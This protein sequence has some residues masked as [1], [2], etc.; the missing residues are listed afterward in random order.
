MAKTT[1][2]P[3]V[4]KASELGKSHRCG[5]YREKNLFLNSESNL[6]FEKAIIIKDSIKALLKEKAKT[7][8][9]SEDVRKEVFEHLME[10][11]SHM[12]YKTQ[13]TARINAEDAYRQIMRY[14]LCETRTPL[15]TLPAVVDVCGMQVKVAPTMVFLTS[16]GVEVV[17]LSASKPKVT[18]KGRKLDDSANSNLELYAMIQYGKRYI[19]QGHEATVKASFYYLR[20]NTDKPSEGKFDLDFWDTASAGNVVSIE[21]RV[22]GGGFQCLFGCK[23]GCEDCENC[24]YPEMC[25]FLPEKSAL[26]LAFEPQVDEFKKGIDKEECTDEMCAACDF[27]HVCNYNEPP[28]ILNK[29]EKRRSIAD[30][31]LTSTQEDAVYFRKGYARIIAG[32]GAGKT[33]V[34]ALRVAMM[35]SEGIKPEEIIMM[36]FTKTGAGEMKERIAMYCDD[37]G[38]ECDLEKLVVTTF[39]AFG[40]E[41]I[42]KFWEKLGF[43][44]EPRL[45][46]VI[47]RSKVIVGLLDK[48]LVPGVDYRNFDMNTMYVRG[49]RSI[50][51]EAFSIIKKEEIGTGEEGRLRS[52]M[53][54]DSRFVSDPQAYKILVDLYYEYDSILRENSLYEYEDQNKLV[55]EYLRKNP[56]F[57]EDMGIK[58]IIVDEF[59]DSNAEQVKLLKEFCDT[60]CFESL[61]T[62]GD[63]AQAIFSFQGGDPSII[64]NL[65]D[66]LGVEGQDIFLVENHRSTKKIIEFANKVIAY[67]T[68]QV[69]KDL[70]ATREEGKP[71]VV[72]GFVEAEDEY[73]YILEGIKS[74]LKD[75]AK[76][77]DIAFIGRNKTE[78]MKLG[79]LLTKENIQWVMLSP[80][81]YTENSRVVAAIELA[82]A[83]NTPN[84]TRCIL[85]YLNCADR[86]ELMSRPTSEIKALVDGMVDKLSYMKRSHSGLTDF[87][88]LLKS[89]DCDDEVY[90][91]FL[92]KL[93]YRKS[94][95]ELVSYCVDF[96]KYG[97]KETYRRKSN[98]EG[99]VLTTAHSSKGLEWPVVYAS[100]STF[101][102]KYEQKLHAFA[103]LEETRRL[104]FVSATRARDEL[105]ITGTYRSGG[106]A[107]APVY[108]KYLKECFDIAEKAFNPVQEIEQ[109]KLKKKAEQEALKDAENAKVMKT[110]TTS[111][112]SA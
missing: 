29:E 92:E 28:I 44:E 6:Y 70:I 54:I 67:N 97:D 25:A 1:N 71:V 37:L 7:G 111:K 95:D 108:N 11:M 27:R 10:T 65:F 53:G 60:K 73:R 87:M 9:L 61:M 38:V 56:Y 98:Y 4:M 80:E 43:S 112:K 18:Q 40:D 2:M 8:T 32:A 17:K 85:P 94:L 15:F 41:I 77:E 24:M 26:D 3:S 19:K 83:L 78:L 30:L 36:T 104:L 58:H 82:K 55:F 74:H 81:L 34:V 76:L 91:A 99:V 64:I 101:Y 79:T 16:D 68:V 45:I 35:L 90:Q 49:A 75:G 22:I 33:L 89:I 23:P 110:K 20:K 59:Q 69:P 102:G 50:T 66:I 107:A 21:D 93:S 13:K 84:A 105:Y 57:L 100:I 46:D 86:G 72:N 42:K 14:V 109:A 63:D 51:S 47:E 103:A 5:F 62:V 48:E 39:N 12:G 96:E 106:N 52:A 88:S 31:E